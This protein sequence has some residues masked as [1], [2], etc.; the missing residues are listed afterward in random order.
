MDF[1]AIFRIEFA[2]QSLD[3]CGC[4]KRPELSIEGNGGKILSVAIGCPDPTDTCWRLGED[5]YEGAYPVVAG[6]TVVGRLTK[7]WNQKQTKKE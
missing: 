4:G 5:G 3:A 1:E 6:K 7:R 2:K